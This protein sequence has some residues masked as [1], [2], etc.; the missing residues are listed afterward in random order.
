MK[1]PSLLHCQL[2]KSDLNIYISLINHNSY[3]NDEITIFVLIHQV[4]NDEAKDGY[5]KI[6][7]QTNWQTKNRDKTHPKTASQCYYGEKS[8]F[9]NLQKRETENVA[10]ERLRLATVNDTKRE[11]E[12]E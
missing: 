6:K 2:T 4:N 1:K 3:E 5:K 12:R 10:P 8:Y 7:I 11:R 9:E